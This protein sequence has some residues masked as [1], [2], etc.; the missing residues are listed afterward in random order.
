MKKGII[1]LTLIILLIFTGTT[2]LAT[3]AA[4]VTPIITP[5]STRIAE[6]GDL[7]VTF[8]V[9]NITFATG[10]NSITFSID[11]DDE[12]FEALDTTSFNASNGWAVVRYEP[13]SKGLS[14]SAQ[15]LQTEAGDI[16]KIDFKAKTGTNGK[17]GVVEFKDIVFKDGFTT[18]YTAENIATSTITIGTQEISPITPTPTPIPDTDPE[19][20]PTPTPTPTPDP[21]KEKPEEIPETGLTDSLSY[22]IIALVVASVVFYINY[23]RLEKKNV[24]YVNIE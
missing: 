10:I 15:N 24:R 13:L 2:V 18:P 17:T 3:E 19:P 6:G 4:S 21:E 22:L 1:T 7:T 5:S 23:K 16:V 8:S 14:L 20:E 9:E 11:Y 12:I